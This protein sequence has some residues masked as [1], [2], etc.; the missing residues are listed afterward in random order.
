[1]ATIVLL[2]IMLIG[3][4][5]AIVYMLRSRGFIVGLILVLVGIGFFGYGQFFGDTLSITWGAMFPWILGSLLIA[6]GLGILVVG[7]IRR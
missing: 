4:V 7:I 1:M 5:A 6:S 3:V 2:I